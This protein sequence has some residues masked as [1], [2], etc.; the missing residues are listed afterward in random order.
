MSVLQH[1]SKAPSAFVS[2]TSYHYIKADINKK[3]AGLLLTLRKLKRQ[4]EAI[5]NSYF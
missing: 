5:Q 3:E 2:L 1:V 4:Q